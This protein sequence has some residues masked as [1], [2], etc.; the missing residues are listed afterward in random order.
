M[1]LTHDSYLSIGFLCM[2]LVIYLCRIKVII[3]CERNHVSKWFNLPCIS[4]SY[5][6]VKRVHETKKYKIICSSF[7]HEPLLL[8]VRKHNIHEW[9]EIRETPFPINMPT[10]FSG[11]PSLSSRRDFWPLLSNQRFARHR[12]SLIYSSRIPALS[13]AHTTNA[14][15]AKPMNLVPAGRSMRRKSSYITFQTSGPT[16]DP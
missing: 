14:S 1:I 16:R 6:D 5:M 15:S 11:K 12:L 13:A 4:W 8:R 7:A 10:G 9:L 3:L 2:R